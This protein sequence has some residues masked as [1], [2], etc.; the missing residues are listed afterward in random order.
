VVA[1][2]IG[3]RAERPNASI[4][5]FEALVDAASDEFQRQIESTL[6]SVSDLR[7]Q[8]ESLEEDLDERLVGIRRCLF[9]E[10]ACNE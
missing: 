6:R 8:V 9:H 2:E 1:G 10:A 3:G 7:F 5:G 4:N